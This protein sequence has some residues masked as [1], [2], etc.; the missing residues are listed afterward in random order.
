MFSESEWPPFFTKYDGHVF[1]RFCRAHDKKLYWWIKVI[2]PD[3]LASKYTGRILIENPSKEVSHSSAHDTVDTAFSHLI[4]VLK[5]LQFKKNDL[6]TIAAIFKSWMGSSCL[7]S[8]SLGHRYYV[9]PKQFC[10]FTYVQDSGIIST[11][12]VPRHFM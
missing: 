3:H 12:T 6:L 1:I 11:K 8:A 10:S 5:K 4:F 2:G 7:F 9:G